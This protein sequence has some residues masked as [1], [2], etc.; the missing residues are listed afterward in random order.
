MDKL[1]KLLE[2]EDHPNIILNSNAYLQIIIAI[3]YKI[4]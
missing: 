1:E 4:N 2:Y 3:I